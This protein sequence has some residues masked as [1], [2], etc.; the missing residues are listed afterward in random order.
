MQVDNTFC[1]ISYKGVNLKESE[2]DEDS[3]FFD[4]TFKPRTA[5]KRGAGYQY[6]E[7]NA[8]SICIFTAID[9]FG[10]VVTRFVNI[11]A[12]NYKALKYNVPADKYLLTV[13]QKDPFS[14]SLCK[15]DEQER[16]KAGDKTLL[17]SDEEKAIIK[18]ANSIEI[19]F[20][21]HVYRRDGIQVRLSDNAH[22]IQKVNALHKRLNDFF[23]K[24]NYISTKYLPGYLTLFEF[25]E[26]TGASEKAISKLFQILSKP[27]LNK[28]SS[29]FEEMFSM[30]NYLQEW[31]ADDN[32]LKKQPY[33]KLM[34]FYLFDHIRHPDEYPS[35]Q[36]SMSDIV[37]ETGYTAPTIRKNY[38]DFVTNGYRDLILEHFRKA[39][40][41]TKTSKN[42][43]KAPKAPSTLNPTVL[44][45]YDEYAQNK[46]LP[47]GKRLTAEQ[48]VTEMN[49]KYGTTFKRANLL[50]K[51]KYIEDSGVRPP[52]PPQK[53]KSE[54][55]RMPEIAFDMFDELESIIM[56][57]RQNG[58]Q[59]PTTFKLYTEL[60]EKYG[61]TYET[62]K[63]YI[64]EAKKYR[65]NN[66]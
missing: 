62:T 29:F 39:E 28:P 36:I 42:E 50:M 5:R 20:E 26:N 63:F 31:L 30:P 23:R 57:H 48:F 15:I 11:G 33:N 54:Y 7:K 56:T 18:Y 60:G 55:Y 41:A 3:I 21:S 46:M 51:F 2:F 24:H 66:K 1:R 4:P 14:L 49:K 59:L 27:G 6:R 8:N 43:H 61:F 10:H 40:S 22:N 53:N 17:V 13:P 65:K 52:I 47:P 25:I 64:T 32:P 9:E 12:T 38:R 19:P 44:S 45:L 37:N 34:A 35:E 58:I 16:S